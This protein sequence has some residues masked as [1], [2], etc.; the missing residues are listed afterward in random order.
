MGDL[1]GTR[2][3]GTICVGYGTVFE[4]AKTAR[5]YASSHHPGQH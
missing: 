4:I 1:F 3:F 2:S 5:G